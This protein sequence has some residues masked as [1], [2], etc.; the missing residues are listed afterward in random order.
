[1]IIQLLHQF[2]EVQ[3]TFYLSSNSNIQP[4]PLSCNVWYDT[5]VP[6]VARFVAGKRYFSKRP[7]EE[8]RPRA[9]PTVS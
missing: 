8:R 7:E 5:V 3:S 1:M 4:E 6:F 2:K 9:R